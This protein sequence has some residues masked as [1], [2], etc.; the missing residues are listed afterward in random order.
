MYQLR[1]IVVMCGFQCLH[2]QLVFQKK[3][4]LPKR[5]S[6][7]WYFI[8]NL[9]LVGLCNRN[10]SLHTKCASVKLSENVKKHEPLSQALVKIINTRKQSTC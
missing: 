5:V 4:T 2:Y 3:G 6:D 8:V 1:H 9:N 10:V 7:L